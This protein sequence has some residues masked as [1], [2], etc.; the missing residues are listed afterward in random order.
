MYEKTILLFILVN[1]PIICFYNQ[2]VKFINI[3][4]IPDK[5]RKLQKKEVP[6]FGGI[7]IIYNLIVF[8]LI[9]Y[10]FILNPYKY[11]F[12]T[13]EHFAFFAGILS[14]FLIG[15]YD[16]KYDLSAIKKLVLNF[17]LI[18]FLILI[19]ETLLISE[20]HFSFNSNSIELRNFSYPFTIL[21]ILLLINALNMFDGANLQVGVYCILILILL[22]IKELYTFINLIIIL[23]LI[24][25][26]IYNYLNK[27]YLGDAGTQIL[28]FLI[29][30]ILIKSHNTSNN[31][32]PD[33]IF[34][35]L[36]F[37]GL[38]MFRLFLFRIINGVSPFKADRNHIH[39]LISYKLGSMLGFFI[40]QCAI[41]INLLLY[42]FLPNKI[43]SIVFIVFLY[44]S[45]L[46]IFKKN[47]S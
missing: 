7:L 4:D 33:Q 36:S 30:Y 20:L 41:I 39:H 26:L 19:D 42:H 38:D 8:F 34:V 43:I 18:L 13:R 24:L 25:F 21:C 47:K 27:A 16:D 28:A 9:D 5:A 12:N 15:L 6:L 46:L 2:L 10:F 35:I 14:C 29:S 31:I 37:P 23:S 17:F 32:T 11:F 44:L 40:I 1:I 3:N 45:L 22:S